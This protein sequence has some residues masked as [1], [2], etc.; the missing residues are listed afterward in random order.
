MNTI[1]NVIEYF[2]KIET[3]AFRSKNVRETACEFLIIDIY[4]KWLPD[5]F[6][7]FSMVLRH[8]YDF[9]IIDVRC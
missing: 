3:S 8:K 4:L 1:E 2:I 9:T 5:A 6:K 7:P